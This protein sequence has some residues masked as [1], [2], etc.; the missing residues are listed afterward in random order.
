[1]VVDLGT[2]RDVVTVRLSWSDGRRRRT[3]I[4]T[5]TDGLSYDSRPATPARDGVTPVGLPARYDAVAV[6]GW[7]PGDARL[8]D[9]AVG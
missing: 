4:E 3:A 5:S 8:V 1:M 9:L 6:T 7:R 2:V